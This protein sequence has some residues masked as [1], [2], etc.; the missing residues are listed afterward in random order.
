MS[1]NQ[2]VLH[3]VIIG[4]IN[5]VLALMFVGVLIWNHA[6]KKTVGTA[7]LLIVFIMVFINAFGL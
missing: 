3:A 6:R 7:L 5:S 2:Y 1:L 4:I